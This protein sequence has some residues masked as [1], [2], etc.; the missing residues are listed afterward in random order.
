MAVLCIVYAV[1]RGPENGYLGGIQSC[2]Q[3]V[4]DLAAHGY[5]HPVWLFQVADIKNSFVGEFIEIEAVAHVVVG[6][7]RLWIVVDHDSAP[8]AAAYGLQG[9]DAAPVDSTELPIR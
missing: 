7:D 5:N 9:I 2:R 8:A 1:G 4:G 6:R 3:I